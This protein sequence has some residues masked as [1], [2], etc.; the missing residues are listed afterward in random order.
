M[1]ESVWTN[2]LQVNTQD[3]LY[4]TTRNGISLD[5]YFVTKKNNKL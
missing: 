5:Q 4:S 3:L 2:V 1:I